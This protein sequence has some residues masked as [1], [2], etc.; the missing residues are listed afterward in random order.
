MTTTNDNYHQH[1][2]TAQATN[3]IRSPGRQTHLAVCGSP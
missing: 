1:T 2:A 3:H